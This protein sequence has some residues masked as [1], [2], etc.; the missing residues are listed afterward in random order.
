MPKPDNPYRVEAERL[1]AYLA[2]A[3]IDL[4]HTHA[5]EAVAQMHG[6]KNYQTLRAS[7]PPENEGATAVSPYAEAHAWIQAHPG[8]GSA[9]GFVKLLL[10]LWN[11]EMAITVRECIDGLDKDRTQLALRVLIH[12]VNYGEDAELIRIGD[13]LSEAFPSYWEQARVATDAKRKVGELWR[14]ADERTDSAP[15]SNGVRIIVENP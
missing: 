11:P 14:E 7:L 9:R 4:K 3:G 5:L 8:T 13:R 2:R 6:F 1:Q 12:F 15:K 10:S